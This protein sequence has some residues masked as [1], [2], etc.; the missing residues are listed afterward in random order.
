MDPV[1]PLWPHQRE[2]A[3]ALESAPAAYAAVYMGGGK[4]RIVVEHVQRH[5]PKHTL[6]VCP[7]P[8]VSVWP[9]EF[10]KYSCDASVISLDRGSVRQ[11]VDAVRAAWLSTKPVVFVTNYESV[12]RQPMGDAFLKAQ[13]DVVVLDEAHRVKS[14]RGKAARYVNRLSRR[15]VKRICLSG[16]PMPHSLMDIWSQMRF[17]SPGLLPGS[18][19]V[20]RSQYAVM[21]GY[22]DRKVIAFQNLPRLNAI[23]SKVMHVV[24]RHDVRRLLDL[25]PFTHQIRHVQMPREAWSVYRSL[26]RD[27]AAEVKA[28]RITA[29]NAMVGLLRLQQVTSGVVPTEEG[30]AAR[31]H[32]AKRDALAELLDDLGRH[33]HVVVFG[34][35]RQDLDS[36]HEAA[37]TAGRPSVELSGRR[38]QVGSLW[39][40]VAAGT[41]AAVQ[42]QAGGVGI[43]LTAAA[44]GVYY[45]GTWSLGDYDQSMA[46]IHRPGQRRAVTYVSLVVPDSVDEI[47]YYALDR[48][49]D[50][51]DA[52]IASIK[53]Q[54]ETRAPDRTDT[55]AVAG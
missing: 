36:I 50:I 25:P 29:A 24:D 44:V 49:R 41:V 3:D 26:E 1:P 53:Q 45:S 48:R 33:E 11:R 7:L 12:W 30:G 47:I 51:V 38:N 52:V 17:L 27:L 4:S 35:F 9:R 13:W 22:Q 54:G 28:G 14:P 20:F 21:G 37:A 31:L 55:A 15:A 10:L 19:V 42:T 43:D 32:N 40:P 2:I 34:R 23:L 39:Q 18:Y 16:T 5:R 6:I 46:R 8:V